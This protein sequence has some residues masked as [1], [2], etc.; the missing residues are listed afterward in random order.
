MSFWSFLVG[1][2]VF[3]K[4]I[5]SYNNFYFTYSTSVLSEEDRFSNSTKAIIYKIAIH[6]NEQLSD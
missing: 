6:F 5:H 2:L 4:K 1:T 3:S